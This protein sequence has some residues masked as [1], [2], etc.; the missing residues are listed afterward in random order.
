MS[1]RTEPMLLR[2]GLLLALAAGPCVLH[3]QPL[4]PKAKLMINLR[5]RPD[6]GSGIVGV[7]NKGDPA[8]V[9]EQQGEFVR[10]RSPGGIEGYLKHKHLDHY[11]GPGAAPA[12]SPP[13][14]PAAPAAAPVESYRS[15]YP[16]EPLVGSRARAPLPAAVPPPMS[17]LRTGSHA[18]VQLTV[19]AGSVLSSQSRE[20]LRGELAQEGF[21]GQVDTLDRAAPA[22]FLRVGYGLGAPWQM[23]VALTYIADLDLRLSSAALT[24]TSLSQSVA[25]HAPASGFALAPT[26]AYRWNWAGNAVSLRAGGHFS[27][28]NETEVRLNGR[29]LEVEYRTH[30]WLA[31]VSWEAAGPSGLWHGLD[32]QV[33]DLNELAGLVSVSL[34]WGQ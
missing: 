2:S 3:A 29:P 20:E 12:A 19:G 17:F 22:G 9:L 26:L 34:R 23:E 14:A 33:T 28:G 8:I 16:V 10:L 31:G 21:G 5:E 13:P 24:P 32:L 18:G 11:T 1:L 30:S 27:L 7:L 4:P 15:P 6:L 25:D